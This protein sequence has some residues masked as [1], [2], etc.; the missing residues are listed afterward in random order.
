M[1]KPTEADALRTEYLSLL[2]T[3]YATSLTGF[4]RAKAF[5]VG[6]F[7]AGLVLNGALFGALFLEDKGAVVMLVL[8]VAV[9]FWWFRK[10]MKEDAKHREVVQIQEADKKRLKDIEREYFALTG[11]EVREALSKVEVYEAFH[12]LYKKRGIHLEKPRS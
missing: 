3:M 5:L 8:V 1:E 7:A 6:N 2:K 11:T 4:F 12:E 10:F 9:A